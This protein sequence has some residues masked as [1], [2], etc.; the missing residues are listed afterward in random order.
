ME[1]S[2]ILKRAWDILWR[3]KALWVFGILVA[4]ATAGGS[5]GGGGSRYSFGREDFSGRF[6]MP[7]IDPAMVSTLIAVGIGVAVF[8]FILFVAIAIA[9]Y[10]AE[11]A[12]IRMV[13]DYED[14]GERHTVRQGFRIG[15]SRSA[16]RLFLIDL[17]VDLPAALAFLL[18]FAL[19]FS[20]LL[21]LLAENDV[22]SALGVVFTIG[23]F[24][25]AIFLAILAYVALSVLKHF[26]RRVCALEKRGVIESI[27]EGYAIVRRNLKDIGLMWLILAGVQITWSLVLIPV[28]FLLIALAAAVGGGLG[29]AAY[30]I[31]GAGD[32]SWLPAVLVGVPIFILLVT[33]PFAFLSGL[34]QTFTSSTWTLAYREVRAMQRLEPKSPEPNVLD[35]GGGPLDFGP[36][37]A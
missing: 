1:H 19:A 30:G 2:K 5:S 6:Q 17:A 37:A 14:T 9:R 22:A 33:L 20:P 24:F 26:A 12:L 15:W 31:A 25:L 16:W 8:L 4:L 11:V 35:L 18:V 7:D 21:L 13:N 28:A 36:P 29:L 23:L 10:V 34:M 27:R 3:Y 32:T